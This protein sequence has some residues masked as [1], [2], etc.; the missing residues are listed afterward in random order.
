MLFVTRA[1]RMA[2][3][4]LLR[5]M[6]LLTTALLLSAGT[7]WG[8]DLNLSINADKSPAL[9]GASVTYTVHVSNSGTSDVTGA[10]VQIV[11]PGSTNRFRP[12]ST[13]D[14]SNIS[15]CGAY[16]EGGETLRWTV[17]SLAAGESRVL[18]YRPIISSSASNA[19][20][21]TP[22]T[23]LVSG[24][25]EATAAVDV[26]VDANSSVVLDIGS[27]VSP[28][29]TGETFDL[30]VNYGALQGRGGAGFAELSM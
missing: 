21:T 28:V 23:V 19:T 24:I 5:T 18:I 7:A 14:P 6:F 3:A 4:L 16:C 11:L 17:G 27:E 10:Q 30:R 15:G 1:W 9:P 20:I 2:A 13:S 22:A 12:G 25:E 8:Q 26:V 29:A